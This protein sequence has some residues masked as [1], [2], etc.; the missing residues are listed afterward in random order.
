MAILGDFAY[1]KSW[2]KGGYFLLSINWKT[3]ATRTIPI[4]IEGFKPKQL[5]LDRFQLLKESNEVF[6][7]ITARIS[8]KESEKYAVQLNDQGTK[9][10][11]FSLSK[12][13]EENILSVSAFRL[14]DGSY[15][16]SGTYAA[17]NTR[18]TAPSEGMFFARGKKDKFDFIKFY[19]YVDLKN[20]L[21]FLPEKQQERIERKRKRAEASNHDFAISY[22]VAIHNIVSL[23]DGFMMLGEAYYATYRTETYTTTSF[24]NGRAVTTTHTRQV[25]D[26]YQYTHAALLRFDMNGKLLWDQIFEMWPSYKPFTVKTFI[27]FLKQDET[28]FKMVFSSRNTI[29][30]KMITTDGQVIQDNVTDKIETEYSGDKVRYSFSNIDYWFD[31]NFIAYGVQVI[32]NKENRNVERKRRV[33]FVTKVEYE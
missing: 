6:L 3:G 21:K 29:V 8:K 27:S 28:L 12:G 33:F 30:S 26:G 20:F 2:T 10:A 24:V 19:K 4:A 25:F 1:F 16:F 7:Y 23:E 9:G 17:P 5:I 14:G 15:A 13:I 11:I 31:N 22:N 32:K 18:A